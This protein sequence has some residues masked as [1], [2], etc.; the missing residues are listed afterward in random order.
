MS[1][2]YFYR[3]MR[4]EILSDFGDNFPLSDEATLDLLIDLQQGLSNIRGKLNR[5]SNRHYNTYVQV[6]GRELTDQLKTVEFL[7][8]LLIVREITN[9]T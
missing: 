9:E 1:K 5:S 7:L 3:K 4:E 2:D 6:F 8:K